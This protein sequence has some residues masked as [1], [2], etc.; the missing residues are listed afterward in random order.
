MDVTPLLSLWFER[1]IRRMS[2]LRRLL[3]DVLWPAYAVN[4]GVRRRRNGA[5]PLCCAAKIPMRKREVLSPTTRSRSQATWPTWGRSTALTALQMLQI[6]G[7]AAP[8]APIS[9]CVQSASRR[10]QK[11]AITGDGTATSRSTA[12][13]SLSGV[14][15]Q[16]EDGP[17]GKSSR[18][19]MLSSNMVLETG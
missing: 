4:T 12:V 11:S 6:C 15:R 14:P 1:G 3:S 7:F 8:T 17:A 19:S 13:G 5:D 2:R 9:S 18:Y 16:R 10:A